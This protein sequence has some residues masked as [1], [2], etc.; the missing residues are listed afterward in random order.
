[1]K[2]YIRDNAFIPPAE[3]NGTLEEAKALADERASY[4]EQSI[5]ITDADGNSVAYRPWEGFRFD[6]ELE[7]EAGIIDFGEWGY[8]GPWQSL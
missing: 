5:Y 7:E 8:Y 3:V 6:P 4:T 2:Y 1:M